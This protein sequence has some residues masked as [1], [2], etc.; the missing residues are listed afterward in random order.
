MRQTSAHRLTPKLCDT[1]TT[2]SAEP[3]SMEDIQ[4]TNVCFPNESAEYRKARNE[5]LKAETE[6]RAHIERVA[7]Q[8]RNLP[9]GGQVKEDYVFQELHE[10]EVR[11]VRLSELFQKN[12]D[13]LFIY[14]FMYAPEMDSACPMCTSLLDGLDGQIRHINQNISTAVVAKH[15][16]HTIHEHARKRGWRSFR[17][18]SSAKNSYNKDYYG[19]IDGQQTTT[20]N[21]FH[22]NN[23][24]IFHFW[25]SELSYQPMMEGGNMRHLDLIW[26]VWNVLDMTPRGRIEDWYPKL[27]Y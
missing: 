11:Q 14:S 12:H 25:N 15:D 21:V 24:K 7:E 26:P 3:H 10:G 13:T 9:A 23:N 17:L 22:L 20:A 8:R 16:I 2:R 1:R 5:L 4:M 6:L 18:L 27:D 19:E